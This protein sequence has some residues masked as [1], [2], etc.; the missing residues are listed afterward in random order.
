MKTGGKT[1]VIAVRID[2]DLKERAET[3]AKQERRSVSSWVEV[4]IADKVAALDPPPRKRAVTDQHR[5]A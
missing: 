1:G 2:P 3:L 4:L 5:A